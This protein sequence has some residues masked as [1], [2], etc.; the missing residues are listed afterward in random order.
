MLLN[1]AEIA[2]RGHSSWL[3]WHDRRLWRNWA[4]DASACNEVSNLSRNH[5]LLCDGLFD[6][7]DR[8]RR[9]GERLLNL[10]TPLVLRQSN[11]VQKLEQRRL[12]TRGQ[13]MHQRRGG[14]ELPL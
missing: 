14:G 5:A 2:V 9:R 4:L 8:R 1:A 11:I 3:D 12:D 6:E 7:L 10:L 13:P